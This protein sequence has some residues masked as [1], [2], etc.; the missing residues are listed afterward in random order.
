M[1]L[2]YDPWEAASSLGVN[3]IERVLPPGWRG[4][5]SHRTRMI[6]LAPGMTFREARSTL[7]HEVQHAIRGDIPSPF[8]PLSKRQELAADRG[9]ALLLVDPVEFRLA[10]ELRGGHLSAVAHELEVTEKVIRMWM[11]LQQSMASR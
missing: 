7:A 6:T 3:V 5:Y 9:A 11:Q 10:E 1:G 4:A 8:G 2:Q